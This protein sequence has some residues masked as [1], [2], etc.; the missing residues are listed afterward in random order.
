MCL[1]MVVESFT[2]LIP[3]GIQESG[4]QVEQHKVRMP[5]AVDRIPHSLVDDIEL[6]QGILIHP[7]PESWQG[8]LGSKYFLPKDLCQ[9]RLICQLICAVIFEICGNDLEDNL[10]EI[11]R[12]TWKRNEAVSLVLKI[13]FKNVNCNNKLDTLC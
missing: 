7:V 9:Y 2:F 8:W 6:L 11:I 3:I 1:V 12:I 4:I 13:L 5:H 10:Q